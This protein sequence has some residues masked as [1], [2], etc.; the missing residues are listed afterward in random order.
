[1]LPYADAL[2]IIL[3]GRE[4]QSTKTVSLNHAL[5]QISAA[6]IT[7]TENIPPF[8][9]SAMDGYAVKSNSVRDATMENP[10]ILCV[11]GS[12]MAGDS[13]S[14]GGDGA[15]EI[16]TGAPVPDAYDAVIRI[17]DTRILET[18][19]KQRPIKI[20]I[21]ERGFPGKNIR[22]A[23]TDFCPG[24]LLIEKRVEIT[25]HHIMVLAALGQDNIPV[26]TPPKAA[27]ISTGKELVDEM[28]RTLLPGQIRNC[29]APYLMQSLKS[30]GIPATNEGTIFDEPEKF[31]QKVREIL[32]KDVQ[33]ILSS[34]AV[35]MGRYDFIPDGLRAMGAEILFHKTA[36]RP[37]KPILFARFPCG[38]TYFGL[39]GNPVASA[40]GLR[41]FAYPL[42][43]KLR[44]M[45]PENPVQ[46]VLKNDFSKDSLFRFFQKSFCQHD[47]KGRL[48][49]EI[50]PGQE[51]FKIK[52]ML[53]QNCWAV[54]PEGGLSLKAG[55]M[56]DIYPLYPGFAA[57]G[58]L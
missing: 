41:F 21:M 10:V 4:P 54:I 17:E 57:G 40:V 58:L 52:P 46:A 48:V 11:D 39:P 14:D 24:D 8:H 33:I 49:V 27:V 29:N 45:K 25:P 22:K 36:I 19:D 53:A 26:T 13:P 1:M 18:N 23:G 5:G 47:E 37:G 3:S 51:S 2:K 15:W 31:E 7:G 38:T 35:S 42:I 44:G 30:H 28:D 9:N 55:T 56:I 50:L 6:R 34:G 43:R 12:T 16:M 32:S 20:S